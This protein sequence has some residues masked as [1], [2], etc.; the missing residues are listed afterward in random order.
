[1]KT[2]YFYGDV[3]VHVLPENKQLADGRI[4]ELGKEY[5][6][7]LRSFKKIYNKTA[8]PN[9]PVPCNYGMHALDTGNSWVWNY[10]NVGAWICVVHV[11]TRV[12]KLAKKVV[13]LRRKV[14]A[15]RQVESHQQADLLRRM[16]PEQVVGWVFCGGEIV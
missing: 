9:E 11:N 6:A 3:Y 13:G 4:V 1:M 5:K 16:W 15:W 2:P 10:P 12:R 14:I 8:R 7:S